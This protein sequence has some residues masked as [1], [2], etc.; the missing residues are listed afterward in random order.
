MGSVKKNSA[1][2]LP[3]RLPFGK[4]IFNDVKNLLEKQEFLTASYIPNGKNIEI[5]FYFEDK[6]ITFKLDRRYKQKIEDEFRKVSQTEYGYHF[7]NGEKS[8][9]V[10]R[11]YFEKMKGGVLCQ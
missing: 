5:T 2:G 7:K 11:K 8:I 4:I 10:S 6:E 3:K 9:I 1:K